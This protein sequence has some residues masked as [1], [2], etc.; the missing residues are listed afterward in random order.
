MTRTS[1]RSSKIA[2]SMLAAA[3]AGSMCIPATAFADPHQEL[4]PVGDPIAASSGR[5]LL[6]DHQ[7]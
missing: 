2:A 7:R 4:I 1:N 3:L 6:R 5:Q